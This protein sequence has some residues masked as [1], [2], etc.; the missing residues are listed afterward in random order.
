VSSFDP[1]SSARLGKLEL[2]NR[3]IG[4]P[5]ERLR[6][7][8]L[9]IAEGGVGLTTIS[10]CTTEADGR[11]MENMMWL[12]E[13]VADELSSLIT[14]IK[15]TGAK[16]S[17]QVTHCGHFSQN[18]S[19]QRDQPPKG[20]SKMFV[21]IGLTAGRPIAPAMTE[22][23]IQHLIGTYRD[24]AAFMKR[25]GFDAMEIHFG[26]GY[27]L[28]QFISPKTNKRT[29]QYGGSHGNRMRVPL[30]CLAAARDAVG[31]DFPILGKISMTDAVKGGI[32]YED[33][34]LVARSLDEAGIDGIIPSGGT[35]SYNSMYLFR[36][37]SIAKGMAAM[38]TSPLVKLLLKAVGPA[39]WKT[40]PYEATYFLEAAGRIKEAVDCPVIYVGGVSTRA[41][42]DRVFKAGFDFVQ[43]G[44]PML[45]D[46]DFVK[47]ARADADYDSGC[48]HCN[49]CVPLI[50]HP[51][52]IR[53]VLNDEKEV[54]HALII[55][56]ATDVWKGLQSLSFVWLSIFF[57]ALTG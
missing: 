45:K 18:K 4:I 56:F 50:Q 43:V 33:G 17:G 49:F 54:A 48:T 55:L 31:P 42:I 27:G 16:V 52:G 29:D 53:C 40:Y 20:P 38:Q 7:F 1:F 13:D 26:H 41:D 11:I 5:G 25:V 32:T 12:R 37:Q 19:L 46:P 15:K 28:S 23:D 35:S 47:N 2:K 9:E 6:E 3:F 8:H 22:D 30:A 24:A 34:I 57:P 10:Y 39:L 21:G 36:G 51:E 44:R 14:D